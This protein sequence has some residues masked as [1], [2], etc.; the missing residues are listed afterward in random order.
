MLIE[1]T[2]T[3]ASS[4][5]VYHH[6]AYPAILRRMAARKRKVTIAKQPTPDAVIFPSLA[7]IVPAYQEAR[8]IEQKIDN[9]AALEYPRDL[10]TIIIGCDGCTDATEVL[11]RQASIRHRLAGIDIRVVSFS[12]N[13]GKVAV[14]NDL[15]SACGS[16]IVALSDVSAMIPADAGLKA[17][18]H[19]ADET[20]GVVCGTY[21]LESAEPAERIYWAHQT[22]IKADEAAVAC[23][24][25]AHGAFYLFRRKLWRR[26]AADTINDDFVLPMSIICGGSRAV[27]DR[28][29][30]AT[31]FDQSSA[32]Q[33]FRRR[34]RI[35][36]GNMQQ[37]LRLWRL[38][39]PSRPGLAF[40]FLSGKGLRPFIPFAMLLSLVASGVM[41]VGG[42]RLGT[43]CTLLQLAL[44]GIA[45]FG[46]A[47]FP[48]RRA[49]I[50]AKLGYL[51][52]GHVAS[53]IGATRYLAGRY[54]GRWERISSA[55]EDLNYT[56]PVASFG[57]RAVDI[58][59]GSAALAIFAVLFFPLA[60]AIKLDSRGPI[61]YRQ[62]RVG[63]QTHWRTE[64]F[65]LI[66]FRTMR[67]DAE[68]GTGP[69]WAS[70]GDPRVTRLGWFLRKSRLDELPQCINV[71]L[72]QMSIVGPRPE[73]PAFFQGL[74]RD[75]PFYVE[76]TYGLKPGITGLAQVNQG[77]DASIE[78]VRN[79]VLWDHAYA[80]QLASPF[81]WFMFDM[82]IVMKT[83]VV[84][85]LH[86][87]SE[88]DSPPMQVRS[89]DRPAK[90]Q[91]A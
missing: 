41:A 36:A 84:M 83:V 51:V 6:L 52:A 15:V 48:S 28:S 26:L 68:S 78:D 85:M 5:V 45:A 69:I 86:R 54:C 17:A 37:T 44:Y 33:D 64:L 59:A 87:G 62:L 21:A 16:D 47:H 74:E 57:K 49:D 63:R 81:A 10:L 91:V 65:Y 9:L 53:L 56:H 82:R 90:R 55:V 89:T 3:V 75:I 34:E 76:R 38:A 79:K 70:A 1:G 14:I 11:A 60:L 46:I 77:Y 8:F 42:S 22:R 43:V 30:V 39:N 27:Y 29:L 73:R 88:P 67:T 18:R 32:R 31:E 19:F 58:V 13:R 72:G 66:K 61:F 12:Q 50:S 7:I 71:L 2:L 20:V 35:G 80:M 25:G 24:M 23:P 40:L 4:L